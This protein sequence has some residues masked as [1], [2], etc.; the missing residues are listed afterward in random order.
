[1][2]RAKCPN[3]S[4]NILALQ[5]LQQ[6]FFCGKSMQSVKIMYLGFKKNVLVELNFI[7]NWL[8]ADDPATGSRCRGAP[9]SDAR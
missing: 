8:L 9:G 7:E 1:M 5:H 2:L 6:S 4:A 3:V